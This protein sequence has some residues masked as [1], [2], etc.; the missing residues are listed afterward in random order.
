M[1]LPTLVEPVKLIRFT[2]GCAIGASTIFGASSGALLRTLTTPFGKPASFNTCPIK[3]W[4]PG[5]S[6][7]ERKITVLPHASAAA[8]ARV[9]RMTGAFQGAIPSTTPT[10]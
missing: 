9:P 4:V 5:Q 2:A 7:E 6:S 1:I 8:I 3:W 10:G